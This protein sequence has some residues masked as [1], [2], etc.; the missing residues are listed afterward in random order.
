VLPGLPATGPLPEQFSATGLGKH[1]EG[2]VVRFIPG[3]ATAWVG[4][5]QPGLGGCSGVFT[6]PAGSLVVVVASGQGYV[7]EPATRHVAY[8]FGGSVESALSVPDMDLLVFQD[9]VHLVAIGP[10]GVAWETERVSWDGIR[11][12]ARDGHQVAGEAWCPVDDRWHAFRVDLRSGHAEG[13]SYSAHELKRTWRERL[14]RWRR[15]RTR[16]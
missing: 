10:A 5:F 14:S 15:R 3:R 16:G 2:F 13:G 8:A 6:H 4:N 11:G 7:V 9:L 12:L 1:R